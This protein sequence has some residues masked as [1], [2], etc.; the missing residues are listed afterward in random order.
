MSPKYQKLRNTQLQGGFFL[1]YRQ[2]H[3]LAY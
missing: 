2:S 1:I 3:H